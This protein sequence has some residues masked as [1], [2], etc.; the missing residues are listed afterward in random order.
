MSQQ[1]IRIAL[2]RVFRELFE[3]EP[4]EFSDSLSREN[5]KSWDSLGHIRLIAAIEAAF[6]VAF[7]IDEIESLTTAARIVERISARS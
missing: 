2:E 7:T 4:F 5:L 3:D 1:D 6:D